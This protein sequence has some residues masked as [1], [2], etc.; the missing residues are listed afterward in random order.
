MTSFEYLSTFG[1]MFPFMLVI[2]KLP[3]NEFLPNANY[4]IITLIPIVMMIIKIM[5]KL[6]KHGFRGVVII[7]RQISTTYTLI[8]IY[9]Q[10]LQNR[11][12]KYER[13]Q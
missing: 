2:R 5:I 11:I 13:R 12:P 1:F 7:K 9:L 6:M 8:S 10:N 3:C 4:S